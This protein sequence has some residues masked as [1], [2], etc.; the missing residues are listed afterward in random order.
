[1]KESLRL[2]KDKFRFVYFRYL[3]IATTTILS[4]SY[5]RWMLD[6]RLG[7]LHLK[8]DLLDFWI[9]FILPL[10]PTAIWLRKPLRILNL[11]GKNDNGYFFYQFIVSIS[12]AVP[13]IIAQGYIKSAGSELHEIKSIY[14]V[15]K[16]KSTDCFKIE[17]ITF[18]RKLWGLHRN[19]RT[20]GRHNEDLIFNN[21]FVVPITDSKHNI[22]K[23]D[24][25]YWLGVKYNETNSNRSSDDVKEKNWQR[26]YHESMEKFNTMDLGSF[27]YLKALAYSDDKDGYIESVK[28]RIKKVDEDNLIILI[29]EDEPFSQR[30][31]KKFPWILGSFGIGAVVFLLMVLLAPIDKDGL[32]RVRQHRPLKEDDF[33]D[34]IKFLIPSGDELVTALL[35]D[36]NILIFIGMVISGLNIVSPT[37]PELMKLGALRRTEVLDGQFWRLFSSMFLHVGMMHLIM[38]SFGIAITCGLIEGTLGRKR[39]I[40]AYIISGVGASLASILIHEHTISVGASGAI[41]GMMG[42]M[43]AFVATKADRGSRVIFLPLV[44]FY[45]GISLLIGFLGGI[46]NAAHIGGLI[47]GFITGLIIIYTNEDEFLMDIEK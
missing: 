15:N 5:L 37:G 41:F 21:Y 35:I 13:I 47:V 4:Y 3:L 2:I 17:D 11:K 6:F 16:V 34:F 33:K 20:R 27:E 9:P 1:M 22:V 42:V 30:L 29:A 24:H 28:S 12:I 32:K 7:V 43:L 38:N 45:G 44:G 40:I 39:T 18:E 8:E 31:G 23:P 19:A 25:R 36:I 46:D 26:F 10:L 14:E